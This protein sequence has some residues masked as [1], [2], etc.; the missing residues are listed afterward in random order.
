MANAH[1]KLQKAVNKLP[2]S[3]E[4]FHSNMTEVWNMPTLFGKFSLLK[5]DFVSKS[6]FS[7]VQDEDIGVG[8]HSK[9]KYYQN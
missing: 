4:K 8:L 9:M 6:L 5:L 3:K 2:S 1:G 7:P